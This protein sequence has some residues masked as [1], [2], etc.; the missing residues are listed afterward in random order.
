FKRHARE[1]I[2]VTL[3][4]SRFAYSPRLANQ[5]SF[6]NGYVFRHA[7]LGGTNP[8]TWF[9]MMRDLDPTADHYRALV[10][11][12]PS[13]D[14]DDEP[15]NPSND[16]RD[17]HYVAVRLRLAD[18]LDFARSFEDTRLR[19]IALRGGIFK[20]FVLQRDIQEFLAAPA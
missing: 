8:R 12:L 1:N 4:D 15:V 18:T 11:G 13:L 2:V 7:G 19:W 17:L 3:G 9:Y 16:G 20:G 10:I 5:R 14:D 6:H